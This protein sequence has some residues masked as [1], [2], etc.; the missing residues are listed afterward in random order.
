MIAPEDGLQA[1]GALLHHA[2]RVPHASSVA[3]VGVVPIE[4]SKFLAHRS[5]DMP[6]A[7]S[8]ALIPSDEATTISHTPNESSSFKAQLLQ[9]LEATPSDERQALLMAHLVTKVAKVI[10]LGSNA[11]IA[12]RQRLFDLGIDS[13][14]A[15]E[16]RNRLENSVGQPLPSTLLF[17]Y[18]TIEALAEYIA[19]DVL[20]LELEQTVE[21]G[22]QE[23]MEEADTSD[24]DE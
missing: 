7:F 5:A 4:W 21:S 12:P 20:G 13:L 3:Q 8:S 14:M 22:T 9:E 11:D 1:L 18:P 2:L 24:D 23:E 19:Q 15:V 6:H 10:G 17:D 16:L